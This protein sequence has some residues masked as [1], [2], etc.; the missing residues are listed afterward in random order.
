MIS[1]VHVKKTVLMLQT[2]EQAVYQ[3]ASEAV[4]VTEWTDRI[5]RNTPPEH[6]VTNVVSGR[7]MR[8]LKYNLADTGEVLNFGFEL[9]DCNCYDLFQSL[10]TVFP[11][12][13]KKILSDLW[14]TICH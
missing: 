12:F 7:K 6:I 11:F 3:E 2:R 5:Y 14:M 13:L 4:Q 1:E 9:C 10:H 8:V